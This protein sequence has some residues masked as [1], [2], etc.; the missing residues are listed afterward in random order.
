M[1]LIFCT[2]CSFNV[3]KK[4]LPAAD[5]RPSYTDCD[6]CKQPTCRGHGRATRGDQFFCIRCITQ[7]AV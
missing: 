6:R 7:G 1:P 2:I 5:R 3:E 4:R